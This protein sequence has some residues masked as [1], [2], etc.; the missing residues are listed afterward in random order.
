M[1]TWLNG[2]FVIALGG[3]DLT[4]GHAGACLVIIEDGGSGRKYAIC[5]AKNVK[6]AHAILLLPFMANTLA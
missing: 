4:D 1:E 6:K 2:C 5:V 3:S